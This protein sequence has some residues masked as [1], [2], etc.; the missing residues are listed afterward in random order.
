M[1]SLLALTG[2]IGRPGAG[3]QFA[4]L[5]SAVFDTVRDP[6]AFYPPKEPD[7]VARI[8]LST[9]RLGREMLATDDPPLKMA[10]VERGNPIPQNP[11]TNSVLEAFRALDFRVVVEQFLTDTAREADIVLPAKTLFEQADVIGA[12][13]HPYIQ[14]KAKV[15]DPPGEVKP[16]SEVY[17]L[18][19]ERLGLPTDE[20]ER[21]IPGPGDDDV[22]AWLRDK[23]SAVPGLDMEQLMASPVLPPG[24]RPV[25]FQDLTFPT[26]SG[27]IEILSTEAER[28]W[29][30]DTLPDWSE[31][32]EARSTTGRDEVP[33]PLYLMTPNTKNR[34]HSQFGNLRMIRA[35]DGEPVIHVSPADALPRGIGE[36]DA[37]RVFNSRGSLE[38]RCRLD[39]GLRAGCVS[40]TKGWWLTSGAAVNVLS[41]GRE[42]DMGH[43]AAFHEN[44]V[45][46][47]RAKA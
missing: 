29:S 45:E 41:A 21:R 27:R 43:G 7:A 8:S 26:P 15:L 11:D 38:I 40:I 39:F 42:T 46:L 10:W 23:V 30:V 34:I 4:N 36:G 44:R 2:N 17:R 32:V 12:Y 19:A 31:P 47:E 37:V 24:Y 3:W 18:L 13:W 25:A 28:R 1:I 33:H 14:Y 20:V 35:H 5:R 16:E 9:A 22:H 6:L